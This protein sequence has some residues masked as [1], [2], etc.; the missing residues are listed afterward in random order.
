MA[1]GQTE[2]LDGR[3]AA[4]EVLEQ[5][6]EALAG[7]SPQA[8]LLLASHDLDLDDFVK[9]ITSAYPDMS[10]MGCTTLA[11][12]SS[13]GNY[14]EGSTI[15][16]L[17]ASDVLEVTTGLGRGVAADSRGA[18]RSAIEQA[19]ANTTKNAAFVIATP[20]VENF[21]PAVIAEEIGDVLGPEVPILGGG[22]VPDYPVAAP[23]LGG[24]QIYGDEI[25]TDS[26]PVLLFS[27]PLDV[28][29]GVAHGWTPVGKEAIVTRADAETV[30]EVDDE[31]VVDFY[32]RYFG[33]DSVPAQAN[34][35]A[36]RDEDTGKF[37][38]RA[39]L[40]Y[41][42]SDGSAT[43]F[44]SIP[45]GATVRLAMATTDEI[46]GGTST[47]VAEAVAAFPSDRSPEA[48]LVV[49]CAVRNLLLGSQSRGEIE[50]IRSGVGESLPVAGFY[51]FGEIAPL[52]RADR[53]RFHNETCVTVLIGT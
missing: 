50:R 8:G 1:I 36:I 18:A 16:T 23:W 14:V 47:S 32:R 25:V 15:L 28:S 22:A 44:G 30:Y 4:E 3:F 48:A 51:S 39:P 31:P 5:C 17:F 26:L 7:L 53:P 37:Y 35:L 11:T 46:L 13:V 29:V 24:I 52:G 21:D 43:F 34:P 49:S 27:G 19:T 41:N 9:A 40:A 2:E 6:S 38:L 33:V 45:E 10:L 12:M 20:T 42:D